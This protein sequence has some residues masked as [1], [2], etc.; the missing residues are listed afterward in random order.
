MTP[1][2]PVGSGKPRNEQAVKCNH[3]EKPPP[4][5]V[6]IES[7][8]KPLTQFPSWDHWCSC[9]PRWDNVIAARQSVQIEGGGQAAQGLNWSLRAQTKRF[10]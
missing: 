6:C 4:I 10:V 2:V 1:W 5:D 8:E 7:K 3:K 9:R